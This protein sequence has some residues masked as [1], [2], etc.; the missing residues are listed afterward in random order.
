MRSQLRFVMHPD[1]EQLLL[2][3]ILTEPA[4]VLIDGPR[5][6]ARSPETARNL[7][8]IG[9]YCIIWSPE[10]LP[11]LEARFMPDAND[12]YCESEHSTIQ[13]LRSSLSGAVLTEGRFAISTEPAPPSAASG[14]ERR[15]KALRKLIR[16][17]YANSTVQWQNP[18]LPFAPAGPSRSANPSKPDASLWVGPD[19]MVWM[20]ADE[21]R[22]IKP[23]LTSH[24]EGILASP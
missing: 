13:F 20:R 4:V 24:V 11:E 16:K 14:V 10:D 19:A 9:S 7:S 21:R 17:T 3:E 6:K 22:R 18:R 12:W 15:F 5:W 1:D 2:D 8:S 23:F